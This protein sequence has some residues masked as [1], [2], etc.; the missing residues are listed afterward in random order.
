MGYFTIPKVIKTIKS[1]APK[2]SKEARIKWLKDTVKKKRQ[3]SKD[4]YEGRFK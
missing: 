3:Y 1:V 4:F 2:P